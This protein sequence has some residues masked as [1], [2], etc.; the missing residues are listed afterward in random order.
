MRRVIDVCALFWQCWI[1][2]QSPFSRYSS[3]TWMLYEE[4][5]FSQFQKKAHQSNVCNRMYPS[6]MGGVE[7]IH[8]SGLLSASLGKP[9]VAKQWPSWH[10]FSTF[11]FA[12]HTHERYVLLSYDVAAIE[13]ITSCHK[14][15]MTTPNNNFA[16]HN[17]INTHR[18]STLKEIS[19]ID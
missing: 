4:Q 15:L 9:L 2:H 18:A 8:H 13:W 5:V 12:S 3:A 6:W 19:Q 17:I 11:V 16:R 7:K 1:R 10:F 14:S